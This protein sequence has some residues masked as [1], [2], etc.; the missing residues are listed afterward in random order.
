M[1]KAMGIMKMAVHDRDDT[2]T[3]MGNKYS[4][5]NGHTED[6]IKSME[7]DEHVQKYK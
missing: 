3:G 7:N 4:K 6:I 1:P 5:H 2:M